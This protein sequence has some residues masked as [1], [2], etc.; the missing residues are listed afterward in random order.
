M[1]VSKEF[2]DTD[3]NLLYHAAL[4]WGENWRRPVGELAV[5][6]LPQRSPEYCSAI[7]LA[8]EQCR[9]EIESRIW[10]LYERL[11]GNWTRADY[12]EVE[13][14]IVEQFPWMTRKKAPHDQPGF[15]LRVARIALRDCSVRSVRCRED[16]AWSF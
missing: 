4:E 8:V 11:E 6:R 9:G 10:D 2:S 3:L 15:L 12:N 14:W 16:G 13:T 7:A 5:E 1:R